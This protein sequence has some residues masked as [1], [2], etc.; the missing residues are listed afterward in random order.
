NAAKILK[1]YSRTFYALMILYVCYELASLGLFV[2]Y[3]DEIIDSCNINKE[4]EKTNCNDAYKNQLMIDIVV[5]MVTIILSVY[6]AMV[7]DSYA[8]KREIKETQQI[9][10]ENEV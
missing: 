3:K 4:D 8:S 5:L 10:T 1:T 7:V 2:G 6:F 9:M